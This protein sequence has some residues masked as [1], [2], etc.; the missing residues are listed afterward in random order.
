MS[1]HV[2]PSIGYNVAVMVATSRGWEVCTKSDGTRIAAP[3]IGAPY[4]GGA[5]VPSSPWTCLEPREIDVIAQDKI[6]LA[7]PHVVCMTF[8]ELSAKAESGVFFQDWRLSG[9]LSDAHSADI[10]SA[11]SEHCQVFG[12]VQAMTLSRDEGEWET[13]TIEGTTGLRVGLHVDNWDR[14][15][16]GSRQT[17]TNRICLNLGP[18]DRYFL[19]LPLAFDNVAEIVERSSPRKMEHLHPTSIAR[20]FMQQ[21][22]K[23]PIFRMRLAPGD[24]YIASTENLVHDGST[25]ELQGDC[26]TLTIRGFIG[27]K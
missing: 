8:P 24:A 5:L 13:T 20:T 4:E 18:R 19:F 21:F 25:Q 23:F 22:P 10:F 12:S 27:P 2:A 14:I 15:P 11:I 17:A 16:I 9:T 26:L 3:S 7:Q 6:D 1:I